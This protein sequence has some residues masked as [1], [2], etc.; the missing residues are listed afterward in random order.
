MIINGH[1]LLEYPLKGYKPN[2]CSGLMVYDEGVLICNIC[3]EAC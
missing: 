3:G 2:P 1:H